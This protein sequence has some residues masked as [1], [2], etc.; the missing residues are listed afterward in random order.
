MYTSHEEARAR[1]FSSSSVVWGTVPSSTMG[2][3]SSPP[4]MPRMFFTLRMLVTFFT[5]LIPSASP[6]MALILLREAGL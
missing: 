3:T 1:R 5:P 6:M 2:F 4:S